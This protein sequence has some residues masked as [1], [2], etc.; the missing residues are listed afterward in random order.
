MKVLIAC[1]YSGIVR[2]AFAARGHD[3]V[4]CD[5]LPTESPGKHE[6]RDVLE[7]IDEGWEL[8]IAHPPCTYLA[9]CGNRS[10]K[11]NPERWRKR[12]EAME[13]VW[14]LW[15]ADIP[16]ICI[17]NP[18]SVISSY[19]RPADQYIHPYEFGHPVRKMTGLWLKG[20]PKLEPTNVVEPDDIL[21]NSKRTKSGKSKYSQLWKLGK[22]HGH[23]RSRFYTGIAEAMAT[24]WGR[25]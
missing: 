2:D 17:E 13:F 14:A 7:I 9:T 23:E 4:S 24:Q 6:Q 21:Y 18:K 5:L 11:S 19:I 15:T 25:F 3:A 16:R 22:G 10:F 8:M 20:L 12:L 1:E